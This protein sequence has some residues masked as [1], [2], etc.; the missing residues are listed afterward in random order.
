MVYSNI[1]NLVLNE[2][3]KL[4][5][6]DVIVFEQLF[7]DLIELQKETRFSITAMVQKAI[8]QFIDREKSGD[9]HVWHDGVKYP[10]PERFRVP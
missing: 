9:N 6:N 1:V 10:I 8:R 2:L 5:N 4:N 3:N 7:S